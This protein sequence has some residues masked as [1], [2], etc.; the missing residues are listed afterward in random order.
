[1]PILKTL[2]T[3]SNPAESFFS[4]AFHH[5]EKRLENGF[6]KI[7]ILINMQIFVSTG[8]IFNLVQDGEVVAVLNSGDA[9]GDT[10]W[11]RPLS[12]S[13]G[14]VKSVTNNAELDLTRRRPLTMFGQR[15][16]KHTS[17]AS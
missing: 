4:L 9:F 7:F 10:V 12:I 2:R 3:E 16:R 17:F 1:M 5:Y 14:R 13:P 11:R 8:E 15:A 6:E